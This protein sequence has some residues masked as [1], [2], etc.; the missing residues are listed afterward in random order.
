KSTE[1]LPWITEVLRPFGHLAI[2]DGGPGLDVTKLMSKAISLHQEMA[3]R[4]VAHNSDPEHQAAI[5]VRVAQFVLGGRMRPITT[6]RLEGLSV[7]TMRTAHAALETGR[8]IG[9]VVIRI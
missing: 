1:N 8:T 9:K 7:E 5:L 6:T 4:R 3:F 2:V